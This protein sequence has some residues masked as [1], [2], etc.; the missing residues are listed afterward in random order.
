MSVPYMTSARALRIQATHNDPVQFNGRTCQPQE[1]AA[2]DAGDG[3]AR[4]D[5]GEEALP[6]NPLHGRC[7]RCQYPPAQF[8]AMFLS[9]KQATDGLELKMNRQKLCLSACLDLY[10][11]AI[12]VQHIARFPVFELVS[13]MRQGGLSRSECTVELTL[14]SDQGRHCKIPALSGNACG[15]RK[16]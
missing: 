11:E 4:V 14:H 2:S 7:A 12:V 10:K 15:S 5:Q 8:F 9:Q 16:A 3:T 13:G 6:S 1:R